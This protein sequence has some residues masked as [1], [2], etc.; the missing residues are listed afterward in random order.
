MMKTKQIK[1]DLLGFMCKSNNRLEKKGEIVYNNKNIK[2]RRKKDVKC[3]W[4]NSAFWKK[5]TF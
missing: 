3:S 1:I 5:N 4:S 2:M